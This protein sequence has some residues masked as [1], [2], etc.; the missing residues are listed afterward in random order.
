MK[1]AVQK[2]G[3]LVPKRLLNGA[4]TVEIRCERGRV[5]ILPLRPS[6]DPLRKLGRHPVRCGVRN[7]AA[8]HDAYLYDTP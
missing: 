1:A 2:S 6:H 4:K 5:V 7:G 8:D 3:V